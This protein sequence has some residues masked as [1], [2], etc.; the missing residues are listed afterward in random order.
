[1]LRFSVM[2]LSLIATFAGSSASAGVY[3]DGLSKCLTNSTTEVDRK[4]LVLWIFVIA[5]AH[6]DAK[7]MA[8][9]TEAQK[10]SLSERTGH[11]MQRLMTEDCRKETVAAIKYEGTAAIETAFGALGEI[12]MTGLMSHPDVAKG[13]D[14]ISIYVDTAKFEALGTDAAKLPTKPAP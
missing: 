8:T 11:L 12:A 6:P 2:L 9:V 4:A 10:E 3:T 13:V 1:M 5:S 14:G 7:G